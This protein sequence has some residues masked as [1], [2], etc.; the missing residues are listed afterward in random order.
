MDKINVY[1]F[2]DLEKMAE[3][4]ETL[5]DILKVAYKKGET[6]TAISAAQAL[7][8]LWKLR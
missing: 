5:L 8:E 7:V 3:T 2:G 4:E 1:K 6:Q